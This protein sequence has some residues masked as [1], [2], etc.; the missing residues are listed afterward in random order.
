MF[1]ISGK[2]KDHLGQALGDIKVLDLWIV[3]NYNACEEKAILCFR[4]S[5][6]KA[7]GRVWV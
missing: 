6:H 7:P 1:V 4:G 5:G 2:E 3:Y